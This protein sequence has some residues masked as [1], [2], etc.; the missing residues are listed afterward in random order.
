MNKSKVQKT[1]FAK[2]SFG[3]NFLVDQNYISKI[4]SA[5]NPQKDDTIIE[6][7]AGRGVLTKILTE[8]GADVI[9]IELER[10]MIAVL[11]ERFAYK[12]NFKLVE[13]DVLKID[14]SALSTQHSAL[15]TKLVANLPYYISTAI[16]QKL[17]EQ[18]D[19]F[20]EMILM[21][22]REV[23]ERITAQAGNSERG[24][25]TVITE[26]YLKTEK[27][28]D[29]P[30]N[31]FLPAPK[32]W[33][34][35]V[36]LTPKQSQIENEKLFRELVSSGFGQK[37]KT[38]LNNLKNFSSAIDMK[39]M[40]DVCDIAAQRRSETLTLAEWKRLSDSIAVVA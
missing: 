6:I 4:I 3:Q 10:N 36:R 16:L 30:P 26:A 14:F 31:A 1:S 40:L 21:F 8:S 11:R 17:I 28:F 15:S 35:V 7:G 27:L 12:E 24:F 39:T 32:V 5:L 2:K 22:Q 37:R 25:L 29:V 38:I 23:V 34:A 18:R 9:A 20:S 19:C 13:S 33:S